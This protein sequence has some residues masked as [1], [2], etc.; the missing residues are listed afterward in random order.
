MR[1][2]EY[3][4]AYRAAYYQR[5]KERAK[6]QSARY[7][8]EHKAEYE[9]QQRRYREKN[10][11]RKRAYTAAWRAA[12]PGRQKEMVR[13]WQRKNRG[14]WIAA[15]RRWQREN[16]REVAE[17]K[18]TPMWAN[19]FFIAEAYDLALLRTKALG[20]PWHVDHI[21]PL[22]AKIV[23]GLHVHNNLRVIPGLVNLAKGNRFWPDMPR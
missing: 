13:E 10:R 23:C 20:Y 19:H 14:R 8:I 21:V 12:N 16:P 2:A 9:D 6:A 1:T 22:R 18:A 7:R 11:A 17:R 3:L 4:R 5:N 15:I